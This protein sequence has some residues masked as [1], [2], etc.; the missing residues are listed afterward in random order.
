[1]ICDIH[2]ILLER[3]LIF[4]NRLLECKALQSLKVSRE[5]ESAASTRLRVVAE[6]AGKAADFLEDAVMDVSV[7]VIADMMV[8]A[9]PGVELSILL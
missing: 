3:A 9:T 1:M 2:E 5:E 6:A 7:V 4:R 8:D